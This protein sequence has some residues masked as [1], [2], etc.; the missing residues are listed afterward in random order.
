MLL[1]YFFPYLSEGIGATTGMYT[2]RSSRKTD[3]IHRRMDWCGCRKNTGQS[4]QVKSFIRR[5]VADHSSKD[6][7]WWKP[8]VEVHNCNLHVC[9][10]QIQYH[11]S[12]YCWTHLFAKFVPF[13]WCRRQINQECDH[14]RTSDATSSIFAKT[15]KATVGCA[16]VCGLPRSDY[17]ASFIS[18]SAAPSLCL[19]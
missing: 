11:A 3:S 4:M 5:R 8:R 18:S 12:D 6:G 17:S 9:S 15:R 16:V 1:A 7:T 19:R 2:V 10:I 14:V 13:A